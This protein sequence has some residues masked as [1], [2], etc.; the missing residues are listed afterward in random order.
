[1][2]RSDF[3]SIFWCLTLPFILGGWI[4]YNWLLIP[5]TVSLIFIYA[6]SNLPGCRFIRKMF[7]RIAFRRQVRQSAR[8]LSP[9]LAYPFLL[10]VEFSAEEDYCAHHH[11]AAVDIITGKVKEIGNDLMKTMT[12]AP[13]PKTWEEIEKTCEEIEIEENKRVITYMDA[14]I[15]RL[16]KLIEQWEKS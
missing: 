10:Y 16:D 7:W 12:D 8:V 6:D 15:S 5:I 3:L 13:T 14:A 1:M 2:S 9:I 4:S 11:R